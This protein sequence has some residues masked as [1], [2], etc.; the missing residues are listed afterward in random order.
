MLG[1]PSSNFLDL[2][3]QLQ[4]QPQ[5]H[6]MFE[7]AHTLPIKPTNALLIQAWH[8]FF[9]HVRFIMEVT[10]NKNNFCIDLWTDHLILETNLLVDAW[11]R[12]SNIGTHSVQA[13][14]PCICTRLGPWTSQ[15]SPSSAP[16]NCDRET[17]PGFFATWN[18]MVS[19]MQQDFVGQICMDD[20]RALE[21][22]ELSKGM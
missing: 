11:L 22:K 15:P 9:F 5:I 19:A 10:I 6:T 7:M 14:R 21:A 16:A 4:C 12:C 1:C 17:S 18:H 13:Q 2:E 20:L 3:N 8:V